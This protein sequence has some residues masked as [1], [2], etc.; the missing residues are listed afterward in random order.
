MKIYFAWF[1]L[2]LAGLLAYSLEAREPNPSVL[3]NGGFE[4]PEVLAAWGQ[5]IYQDG[6]PPI[7]RA[8]TSERVEGRQSVLIEAQDPADVALGQ[9]AV[10]PSG[11]LWRVKARMKC[12]NLVART[13]TD[14]GAALHVQTPAGATLAC[15]PSTFGTSPWK[16]LQVVFRVPSD[17]KVKVVL[18]FIGY[19]KG[20]GKVWFDEVQLEPIHTRGPER[21]QITAERLSTRPID[22][23]QGGQFIEPLCHLIPSLVAQQVANTSF[24]IDPPWNVAFRGEID[25]PHRPW[26]PDGAVHLARYTYDTNQTFNGSRSLRIEL[27]TPHARPGI[28]QE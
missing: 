9:V 18:F 7:L 21:I 25:K 13:P 11:S 4:S 15:G 23:K 8:D 19:G 12:E 3:V 26:Y 5:W 1:G 16:Q 17:G 2:L 28:S 20:T 6:R 14:T 24:E 22:A 10:L 27:N